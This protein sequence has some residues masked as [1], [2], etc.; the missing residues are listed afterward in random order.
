MTRGEYIAFLRRDWETN[1]R[2]IDSPI[3]Q[4]MPIAFWSR[5]WEYR[6]QS[7]VINFRITR[8]FYD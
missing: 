2:I 7:M 6:I 8:Y 1:E 4:T 5:C 3:K